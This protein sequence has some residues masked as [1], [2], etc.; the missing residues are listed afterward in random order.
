MLNNNAVN[1]A[2]DTCKQTFI[3]STDLLYCFPRRG[4]SVRAPRCWCW[5]SHRSSAW[6]NISIKPTFSGIFLVRL[7]PG[8]I[9]FTW[10]TFRERLPNNSKYWFKNFGYKT[11]HLPTDSSPHPLTCKR[12]T[13]SFAIDSIHMTATPNPRNASA[14]NVQHTLHQHHTFRTVIIQKE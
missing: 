3:W 13:I 5:R 9:Q 8:V 2:H 6:K 11:A 10:R 14:C 12:L 1:N 4:T 7:P